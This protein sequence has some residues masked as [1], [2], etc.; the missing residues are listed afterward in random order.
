MKMPSRL[1]LACVAILAAADCTKGK[2]EDYRGAGLPA[3]TLLLND[4]IMLYRA[5]LWA[6]FPMDD[7]NTSI[8]VDPLYLPRSEGLSGGDAMTIEII[9]AMKAMGVVKGACQ[10]PVS[11][12]PVPLT[13]PTAERPGYVVRFSQPYHLGQDSLQVHMAAQ[14]Y[15]LPTGPK[16]ERSRYEHAYIMVRT[17]TG[18]KGVGEAKMPN[19]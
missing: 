13:C 11:E 18:W 10:L 14:N 17:A 1:A 19:P 16:V 8:F 12:S 15:N 5:V 9:N 3:D 7:P 4:Q 2:V 6:S